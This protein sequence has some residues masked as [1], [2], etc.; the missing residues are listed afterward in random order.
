LALANHFDQQDTLGCDHPAATSQQL[1]FMDI[2]PCLGVIG[3][4]G[5]SA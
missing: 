5:R 3:Q 2:D 4:G 1:D